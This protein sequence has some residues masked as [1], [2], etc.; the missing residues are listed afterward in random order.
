M[1]LRSAPPSVPYTCLYR[2]F[3]RGL[4]CTGTA[5]CVNRHAIGYHHS[6]PLG[7][8]HAGT[9]RRRTL[10]MHPQQAPR[11]GH[12]R[13]PLRQRCIA[14]RAFLS[15]RVPSAFSALRAHFPSQTDHLGHQIWQAMTRAQ[16]AHRISFDLASPRLSLS[17]PRTNLVAMPCRAPHSV[18][19]SSSRRLRACQIRADSQHTDRPRLRLT[20]P[21]IPA[22]PCSTHWACHTRAH[23]GYIGAVP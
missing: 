5:C 10:S 18:R 15:C 13:D 11:R 19:T 3:A 8:S 16:Q 17:H 1:A 21:A 7:V 23:P 20:L 12:P 6:V 2:K 4:V 9:Y 22:V 14:V